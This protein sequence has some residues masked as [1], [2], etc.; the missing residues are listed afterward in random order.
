[1]GSGC[2][3]RP[4]ARAEPRRPSRGSADPVGLIRER[5]SLLDGHLLPPRN[6]PWAGPAHGDTG[7]QLPQRPRPRRLGAVR[8][9]PQPATGVPAVGRGHRASPCRVGRD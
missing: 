3:P 2:E 9:P 6:Q 7:A 4:L 5:T 8:R 1:M